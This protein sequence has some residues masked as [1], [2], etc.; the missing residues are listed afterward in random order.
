MHRAVL[1]TVL[2]L[3]GCA[4]TAETAGEGA[5]RGAVKEAVKES[6]GGQIRGVSDEAAD[7]VMDA[8]VQRADDP[9]KRFAKA[10]GEVIVD[11]GR[12]VSTGVD[13]EGEDD[14]LGANLEEGA[15]RI[16]GGAAQGVLDKSETTARAAREIGEAAGQAFAGAFI[17]GFS[18]VIKDELGPEGKGPLARSIAA[19]AERTTA[20]SVRGGRAAGLEPLSEEQLAW[21]EEVAHRVSHGAAA[22]ATVGV[23][24]QFEWTAY[25]LP[26]LG[27]VL[28]ML[29]VGAAFRVMV[30]AH[31][32]RHGEVPARG[33]DRG[34][35][36]KVG[37]SPA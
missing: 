15:R 26:F 30:L 12:T 23:K 4:G 2:A 17:R 7:G 3:S 32:R 20:A 25:V 13:L 34:F 27:G 5:G 24:R 31:W 9:D 14:R 33:S 1:L 35:A 36:G 37:P 16:A 6:R 29:I 19:T 8:F 10:I 18:G 22:G 11:T 28:T 21:I